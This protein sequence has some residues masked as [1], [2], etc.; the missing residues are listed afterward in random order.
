[1]WKGLENR[2][3]FIEYSPPVGQLTG[4]FPIVGLIGKLVKPTLKGWYIQPFSVG[5]KKYH[6]K[7]IALVGGEKKE[8]L[9]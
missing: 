1:M 3:C 5:L 7:I 4:G 8:Y 6:K 2:E 9:L